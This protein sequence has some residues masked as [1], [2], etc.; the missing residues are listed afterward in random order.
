[1]RKLIASS[2]VTL[3]GVIQDPGGFGETDQ[4]G[5]AGPY[6]NDEAARS[7]LDQLLACDYFLCGRR[8]YELFSTFWPRGDGPYPDRMN[9]MPK[10]VASTTLTEPLDWNARRIEGDVPEAIRRLKRDGGGN[11]IMYGSPTLLRSLLRHDL[12]DELKLSVAPIVLG[13]GTR[14]FSDSAEPARLRLVA[15]EPLDSGMVML[16]YEPAR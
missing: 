10:L 6:F 14:L 8:T 11:V 7:S 3:D 1:M 15:T 13:G 9:A 16:T 5:W 2:L 4:G 12:V